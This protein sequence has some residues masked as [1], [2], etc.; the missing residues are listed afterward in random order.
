MRTQETDVEVFGGEVESLTTAG[1]E[2]VGVR[3]IVDHR[4]GYA[5]AGSLDPDV[6]DE[7]LAEARDNADVR[8]ARRVV[9]ARDAR[10]RR[11]RRRA[12][13]LDLWRDELAPVPTDEKVRI[14]LELE[15][16]DQGRR[17]ADPQRRSRE[18][19]RR[20]GREPRS[21]TR[22]AS[23]RRTRRTTVLGVVGRA[24]R[25]RHRH[26]DRLRLRRRPHARRSRSRRRSRATPSTRA[27]RLLGAKPIAGRRIPVDPRPARDPLGARRAVERVQRRVDAEGPLAV[28][29]PRRR[30]DR[31]A[32]RRSCST[33]RPIRA[34]SARRTYDSE[35]VPTRRNALIADGV[36]AGLP[37]QRVHGP[38][39]RR[40]ARR[41]ARCAAATARHPASACAR[42]R[43]EPGSRSRPRQIMASVPRSVLRAVGERSALG[44]EPDQR[45]LLGR[46]RRPDGARRRVR[47]A[48]ARGDDRVDAAA[49]AARHRRDRRPTSRSCPA[50]SRA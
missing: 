32:G 1:V 13:T 39:L 48:G 34:R 10:R 3:V 27:C 38:A 5:W 33:T 44:H 46:R 4:Q 2:G 14:A 30:E 12:P 50:R 41:A 36:L 8:R 49:H 23:R 9:R 43:L 20:A 16:R 40:R 47:R 11:R 25:R 45:R 37:A 35:G 7:T 17:P 19:R 22:S 29:G 28:R 6:V 26:A 15:A 21:R 31:G 42:L 18:L 24:R